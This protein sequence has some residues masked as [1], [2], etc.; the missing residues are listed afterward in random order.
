[1]NIK[2][3]IVLIALLV[4]LSLN[5]MQKT[6]DNAVESIKKQC[7]EKG[8][9]ALEKGA[10]IDFDA[11]VGDASCQTRALMVVCIYNKFI[12][13]EPL[14]EEDEEIIMLCRLLTGTKKPIASKK[15]GLVMDDKT[16]FKNL[17]KGLNSQIKVSGK[18]QKRLIN[19]SQKLLSALSV[20][21]FKELHGMLS[22]DL[23]KLCNFVLNDKL[24][25]S[26][27]A[28]Y[29]SVKALLD[30]ILFKKILLGLD[31]IYL[32][33]S[34]NLIQRKFLLFKL[35]NT[36]FHYVENFADL[37]AKSA[38]LIFEG[39]CAHDISEIYNAPVSDLIGCED[40]DSYLIRLSRADICKIL[41]ANAAYHTQFTDTNESRCIPFKEWGLLSHEVEFE[42]LKKFAETEGCHLKNSK[43][44]LT[45]H[46]YCN[47]IG[48][49]KGL[50]NE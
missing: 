6:S 19:E 27:I 21:F 22:D 29:V 4:V 7:L 32:C 13:N 3:A 12:N 49:I 24:G 30:A 1:M 25:R 40:F 45:Q 14:S 26:Q 36:V 18:Q 9:E 35:E 17:L 33:S 20:K 47:T 31:I 11:L 44:F 41:L 48:K 38:V 28:C 10:L 39:S 23:N 34:C 37:D 42:E 5:P 16:D 2:I 46:I 15:N 50:N 43:L 8:I